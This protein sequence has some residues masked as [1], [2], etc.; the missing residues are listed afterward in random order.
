MIAPRPVA[1][2]LAEAAAARRVRATTLSWIMLSSVSRSASARVPFI[3]IP[4]LLTSRLMLESLRRRC[5]TLSRSAL[6]VRSALSTSTLTPFSFCRRS[7][8]A[9]RRCW[10]RAT[11]SRS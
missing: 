2:K 7:A 11:S 3:A 1:P 4:A 5:S 9:S 10:S 8:M 6:L